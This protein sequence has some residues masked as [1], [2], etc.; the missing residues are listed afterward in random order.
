MSTHPNS[1]YCSGLFEPEPLS[2]RT[3]ASESLWDPGDNPEQAL[4]KRQESSILADWAEGLGGASRDVARAL[5]A[6]ETQATFARR[7][8]ISEAAVSKRVAR[9]ARQ[10]RRDLPML[11]RAALMR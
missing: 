5:L 4:I 2:R 10:G 6:G 8:G 1:I 3:A 11:R 9:L 7:A